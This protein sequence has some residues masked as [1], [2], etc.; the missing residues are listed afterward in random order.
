MKKPI[1]IGTIILLVMLA[2]MD[3]YLLTA[4]INAC[5]IHEPVNLIAIFASG[6]PLIEGRF[7]QDTP[8]WLVLICANALSLCIYIPVLVVGVACVRSTRRVKR[9]SEPA[10]AGDAGK[11]RP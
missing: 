10:H 8:E 7:S 1:I 6:I 2:L 5:T 9:N 4:S 11:P 3:G